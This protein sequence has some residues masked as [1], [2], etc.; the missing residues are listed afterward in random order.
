MIST[1]RRICASV[2]E[3]PVVSRRLLRAMSAG[4][5]M[6]SS[7]WDGSSDAEVQA[8]PLEA[9]IPAAS[10]RSSSASLSTPSITKLAEFGRRPS[11][12]PVRRTRGISVRPSH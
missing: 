7:T 12:G 3:R 1:A 10:S 2:F 4:M 5:P 9:A 6:A 8:E 11:A